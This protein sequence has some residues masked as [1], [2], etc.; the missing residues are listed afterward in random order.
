MLAKVLHFI[1]KGD[2]QED[3]WKTT[4]EIVYRHPYTLYGQNWT[5]LLVIEHLYT[6]VIQ[7]ALF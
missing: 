5:H 3:E 7:N 1:C 6:F 4:Y 2:F